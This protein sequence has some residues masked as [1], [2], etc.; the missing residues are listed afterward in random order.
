M[1]LV[2]SFESLT[3]IETYNTYQYFLLDL[4][5]I[6]PDDLPVYHINDTMMHDM[7]NSPSE[8]FKNMYKKARKFDWFYDFT[9]WPTILER[10]MEGK[11]AFLLVST[12][13]NDILTK[14]VKKGSVPGLKLL[15]V[16]T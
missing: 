8:R 14:K 2:H 7:I 1:S 15:E 6:D 5:K 9:I 3:L 11:S 13:Y 12:I 4:L 16:S 10:L